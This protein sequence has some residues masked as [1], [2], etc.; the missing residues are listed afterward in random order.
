M[1]MQC[2]KKYREQEGKRIQVL[3]IFHTRHQENQPVQMLPLTGEMDVLRLLK[4]V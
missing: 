4:E 1:P 3:K 2:M